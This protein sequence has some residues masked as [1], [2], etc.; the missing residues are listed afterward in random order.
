MQNSGMC[1]NDSQNISC[2]GHSSSCQHLQ[3]RVLVLVKLQSI[4]LCSGSSSAAMYTLAW[5]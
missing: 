2:C 5:V 1:A 4:W 3:K